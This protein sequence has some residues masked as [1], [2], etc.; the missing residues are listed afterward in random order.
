MPI[1]KDS[2]S[3]VVEYNQGLGAKLGLVQNLE[4]LCRAYN[5]GMAL[6]MDFFVG[7]DLGTITILR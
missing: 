2:E 6:R 5:Q 3:L 4:G 7:D 1:L